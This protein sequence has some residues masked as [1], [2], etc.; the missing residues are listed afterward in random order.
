MFTPKGLQVLEYNVR[1]GDPECQ[2][3]LMRLDGDL[4]EI[5]LACIEGRLPEVE[6][7]AR[8]EAALGVVLAAGGYPASYPKGM[9]I[10]GIAEAEALSGVKV[11]QAGTAV[12]NGGVVTSGGRVLCVTALGQGLAQ[13][14][15][16]AYEAVALVHF[17]NSFHRRDIGDKGLKRLG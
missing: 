4:V 3:L 5:M 2:P 8:P 13:A 6:V 10:S 17:E 15:K 9:E 7:K 14:K 1:F 12:D 16:R 11:F